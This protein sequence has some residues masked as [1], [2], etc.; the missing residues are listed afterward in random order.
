LTRDEVSALEHVSHHCGLA[1]HHLS[2]SLPTFSK[3]DGMCIPRSQVLE[4]M[5][6]KSDHINQTQL[7]PHA[8]SDMFHMVGL[9]KFYSILI[10]LMLVNNISL[11]NS[12][13]SK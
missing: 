2:S 8:P 5:S 10:I 6:L 3:S 4:I 7:N 13:S 12:C 1:D 9:H 11:G